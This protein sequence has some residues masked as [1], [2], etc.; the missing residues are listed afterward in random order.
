MNPIKIG[1]IRE[2]KIPA[3]K[4]VPLSP[5]QAALVQSNFEN[6]KIFVQ[7]SPIRCFSDEEYRAEGISVVESVEE[8]DILMG[9]KEVP[10]AQ[11]IPEKT[12]LFFSHTI[13]KQPYNRLLLQNI[14]EKKIRLIDY[15]CLTDEKGN[16]VIAFGRYAGLVGAY[17]G[18]W[19]YGQR[20]GLFDIKRAHQCFDLKEMLQEIKKVTLPPMKI[21]LNGGGRVGKGSKE[22][23]DAMGI[24]QVSPKEYLENEFNEAVYTQLGSDDYHTRISDKGFEKSEFYSNP[25]RY[26]SHFINFAKHTDL[27]L[28]AAYWNPKAP[29]LFSKEEMASADFRIKVIADI[30]CDIDGSIPSTLRAST[31]EAPLYDYDPI[32]RSEKPALSS[33]SHITIMAIDNLP[34]ELP[35]DASQDFGNELLHTVLPALLGQ[36][37]KRM[38]ERAT[39][40]ENGALCERFSYLEDYV[41]AA[42][43]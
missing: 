42:R 30:T 37:E 13:K 36:D 32:S 43:H 22:V 15:E 33:T 18:I 3:D 6:L 39:I 17:N 14:L 5:K 4:R 28:A 12:Y 41:S 24:K 11:L 40:A 27:L 7:S 35:R 23:L 31:I 2:G 25:E 38:I 20:T 8:C 21:A 29:R 26:T 16:R 1:L 34:C 10:I 9:V 19:A